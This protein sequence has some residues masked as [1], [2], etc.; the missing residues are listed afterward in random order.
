MFV[1]LNSV[2]IH[3]T[4]KKKEGKKQ[5]IIFLFLFYLYSKF[6]F[7][8]A[9]KLHLYV[10]KSSIYKYLSVQEVSEEVQTKIIEVTFVRL[11][12]Y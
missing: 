11:T 6:Y 7:Y 12:K 8:H 10:I 1:E 3:V 2:D 9:S 5:M 4:T